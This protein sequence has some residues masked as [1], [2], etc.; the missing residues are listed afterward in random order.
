MLLIK[1]NE[2]EIVK[3]QKDNPDMNVFTGLAFPEEDA[4]TFDYSQLSDEQRASLAM[5][6][7]EELAEIM[8]TYSNNAN[9]SYEGNLEY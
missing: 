9:A 5:L 2:A 7:T 1:P 8:E 4:K 3:E 6:S